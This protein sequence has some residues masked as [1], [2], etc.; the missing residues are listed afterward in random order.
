M[1]TRARRRHVMQISFCHTMNTVTD[2]VDAYLWVTHVLLCVYNLL[3]DTAIQTAINT[4]IGVRVALLMV[5]I[6]FAVM[7]WTVKLCGV[8]PWMV[9]FGAHLRED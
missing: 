9:R 4:P 5:L 3:H 6:P 7:W 8:R 2:V 1:A